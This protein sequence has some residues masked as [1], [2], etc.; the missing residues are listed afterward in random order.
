MR[1]VARALEQIDAIH[2]HL[3]RSDVYRG[4]RP[5]PVAATGL[6]GLA[7]AAWQA[8]AARPVEPWSF[9][10][11]WLA[12]ALVALAIGCSEI[13]W[14]YTRAA[15]ADRR[16]TRSVL[17]QFLPALV[18]GAI[19]TAAMLKLSPALIVLLPGLWA[20]LFGVGVFAASPYLPRGSR[21]VALYY[22]TVGLGLLWTAGGIDALSPWA[23]GVTFG[24]GQ[25]FGAV[26]I[27]RSQQTRS[28]ESGHVQTHR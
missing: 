10:G 16:H 4:W 5:V 17:G 7:A 12:V 3:A 23:V 11:F 21:L 13:V 15:P 9:A 22:W 19:V 8:A 2:E 20:L 28:E 27:A 26:V 1:D 24:V 25:L 18:A 14:H 6:I